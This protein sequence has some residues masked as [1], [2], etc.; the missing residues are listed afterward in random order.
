M[1]EI[2]VSV[3][4]ILDGSFVIQQEG[5]V[6]EK[7]LN[8]LEELQDISEQIDMAQILSKCG[9]IRAM[10]ALADSNLEFVSNNVKAQA[11]S[12]IGT[13]VQNNMKVQD[14]NFSSGVLNILV[15]LFNSTESTFVRNK[16][17]NVKSL[18]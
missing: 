12:V 2:M 8:D 15:G 16:V 4:S 7:L 17:I 10:I 9:G 1:N 6:E 14:E 18:E 3:Y 11:I 13:V 5:S